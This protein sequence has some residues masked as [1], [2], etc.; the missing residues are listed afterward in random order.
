MIKLAAFI[1]AGLAGVL[2]GFQISLALGA[3][4]GHLAMGGQWPGVLPDGLRIATMF[5][6][7]LIAVFALVVLRRAGVIAKPNF[8]AWSIWVVLVFSTLAVIANLATP[9]LAERALW[10]PVTIAMWVSC[11]RVWLAGR[12]S[13]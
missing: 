5:Q 7:V 3:P 9:S 8:P 11:I 6:G 10:A 13:H 12:I 4:L 1:Y 2:F